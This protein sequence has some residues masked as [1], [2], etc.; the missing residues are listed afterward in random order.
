[1]APQKS[2]CFILESTGFQTVEIWVTKVP[3]ILIANHF[4]PAHE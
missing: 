1:M 3:P 2:F 4:L